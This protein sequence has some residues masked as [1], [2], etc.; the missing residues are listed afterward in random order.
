MIVATQPLDPTGSCHVLTEVGISRI[1]LASPRSL[2]CHCFAYEVSRRRVSTLN[3]K[4]GADRPAQSDLALASA[5]SQTPTAI[6]ES[7]YVKI[8]GEPDTVL[9]SV[10][11]CSRLLV[12]NHETLLFGL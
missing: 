7:C 6:F 12:T 4:A 10:H 11:A 9:R 5:D 2:V 3:R 1:L 8:A